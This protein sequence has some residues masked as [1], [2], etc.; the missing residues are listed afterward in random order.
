MSESR[1]AAEIAVAKKKLE[2]SKRNVPQS[3]Y[4]KERSKEG[5]LDDFEPTLRDAQREL[6]IIERKAEKEAT[7]ESDVEYDSPCYEQP[8]RTG[9]NP[10]KGNDV[11]QEY[12]NVKADGPG[13]NEVGN[14]SGKG[15]NIRQIFNGLNLAGNGTNV[16]GCNTTTRAGP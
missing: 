10:Q 2:R 3:S 13:R 7:S 1:R 6:A 8:S 14:Y 12:T 9:T 15:N 16:F 5:K 4:S 11:V